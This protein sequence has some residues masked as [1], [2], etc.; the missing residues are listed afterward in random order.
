ME[1]FSPEHASS[2][3]L[4]RKI[5]AMKQEIERIAA[6]E[7]FKKVQEQYNKARA[8]KAARDKEPRSHDDY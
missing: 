3:V 4:Q 5:R 7:E 2:E 8:A 1:D 6:L